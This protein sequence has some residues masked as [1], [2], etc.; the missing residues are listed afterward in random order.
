MKKA[1]GTDHFSRVTVNG[2]EAKGVKI[3]GIT[4]IPDEKGSFLNS[5][6]GYLLNDNGTCRVRTYLQVLELAK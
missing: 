3:T 1:V 4:A 2:L 6:T 5:S